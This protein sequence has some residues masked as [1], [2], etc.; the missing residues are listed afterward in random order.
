MAAPRKVQAKII[1]I[2]HFDKGVT[3]F[4]FQ[5]EIKPRYRAG[6]F[7]HLAVDPYDPSYNWPESRVF[8]IANRP[9]DKGIIEI[10]VA[11]KGKFTGRM[12]S[13]LQV[14]DVVWLKLPFGDFNFLNAHGQDVV[15]VAGGTGISPF[16]P[17]IEFV[18]N[19]EIK[20]K[21]VNLYYGV[22]HPGLII[23]DDILVKASRD[24]FINTKVYIEEGDSTMLESYKG[25]LPLYEIVKNHESQLDCC[26]YLSG[27]K[28]MIDLFNIEIQKK[29]ST[30]CKVFYDKWE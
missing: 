9:D 11:P 21:S 17:F 22:K 1:E 29:H 30:S 23:F 2:K 4:R 16:I 24:G 6:Q 12:V 28:E 14:G 27:P 8:S 13:E 19:G 15:L 20:C 3:L 26:Y 7:L 10:L 18:I 25:R 5:S